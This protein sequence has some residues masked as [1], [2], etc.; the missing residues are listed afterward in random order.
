MPIVKVN[1]Q[2][3]M[4][5]PNR[6]RFHLIFVVLF[7]GSAAVAAN[8]FVATGSNSSAATCRWNTGPD[9]DSAADNL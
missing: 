6:A 5:K 1:S 2:N 8:R 7:G 3:R 4:E 9:D